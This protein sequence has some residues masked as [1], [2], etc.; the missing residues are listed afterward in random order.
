MRLWVRSLTW[1]LL[2]CHVLLL[3]AASAQTS[4][5]AITG[6]VQDPTGSVL[7]G[8]KVTLE[9]S[10]R[11]AATDNQGQFR[12]SNLAPGAYTLTASY[13]GFSDFTSTVTV[14]SGQ[15]ANVVASMKVPSSS[16]AVIVTAPRLQGDAEAVNVERMSDQIVQ[17]APAGVITS[18]PNTNIADAIG[19]LPSVSL[20]R[21]EG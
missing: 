9:P 18:L 5:W 14:T 1:A 17:V 21:D 4:S 11:L 2:I 7:V 12:F 16:D 6:T 3:P 15:T 10:G 8:A 20:E 19:R 13:L